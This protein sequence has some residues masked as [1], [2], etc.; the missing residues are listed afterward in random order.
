MSGYRIRSLTGTEGLRPPRPDKMPEK[1][2]LLTARCWAQD[3]KLRPKFTAIGKEIAQMYTPRDS[4]R[5]GST[6]TGKP[7]I[8]SW[9]TCSASSESTDNE[10]AWATASEGE[11]EEDQQYVSSA[12]RQLTIDSF[13]PLHIFCRW[14]SPSKRNRRRLLRS[15]RFHLISSTRPRTKVIEPRNTIVTIS[16]TTLTIV[17]RSPCGSPAPWL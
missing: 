13:R 4:L 16:H 14:P 10:T 6:Q 5:Q 8:H 17:C 15:D 3:P 7:I 2:W 9:L 1:L 12:T 11:S